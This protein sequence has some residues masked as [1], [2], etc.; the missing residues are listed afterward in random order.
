MSIGENNREKITS[1]RFEARGFVG[2]IFQQ[3][4]H[5]AVLPHGDEGIAE[6]IR[7]RLDKRFGEGVCGEL[8]GFPDWGARVGQINQMAGQIAEFY[9]QDSKKIFAQLER[10]YFAQAIATHTETLMGII[11]FSG[12]KPLN[13]LVGLSIA[14]LDFGK[15]GNELLEIAKFCTTEAG[16]AYYALAALR[17]RFEKNPALFVD[18]AR[19]SGRNADR[20]FEGIAQPPFSTLL[21][22]DPGQALVRLELFCR[23]AGPENALGYLKYPD[24]SKML[25]ENPEAVFEICRRSAGGEMPDL[26]LALFSLACAPGEIGI[27]GLV[28]ETMKRY[29]AFSELGIENP[30]RYGARVLESAY[31]TSTGQ[32]SG[33]LAIFIMNKNDPFGVFENFRLKLPQLLDNGYGIIICETAKVADAEERLFGHG[34]REGSAVSRSLAGREFDFIGVAG[35]GAKGKKLIFGTEGEE[36]S[37]LAVGNEIMFRRDWRKIA[38]R[39]CMIGLFSCEA[40]S[41]IAAEDSTSGNL[42]GYVER[43]SGLPTSALMT[44]GSLDGFEFDGEGYVRKILWFETS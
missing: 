24:I 12:G 35:H 39:R 19:I 4:K 31:K 25:F 21:D 5:E 22:G 30:Q 33:K 10:K 11:N 8:A 42:R 43:K 6:K 15:Y 20:V 29:A 32:T 40:D 18:I 13:S 27:D 34:G 16:G 44:S 14:N 7:E 17:G 9:P 3:K 41:G 26:G 38:A 37:E 2:A 1:W 36:G 28:D 23:F